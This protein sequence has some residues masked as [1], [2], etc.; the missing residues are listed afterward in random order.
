[1]KVEVKVEVNVSERYAAPRG[2]CS[3]VG[4]ELREKSVKSSVPGQYVLEKAELSTGP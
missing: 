2:Q 1:M 4:K 3:Q